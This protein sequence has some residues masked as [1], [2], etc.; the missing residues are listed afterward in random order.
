M[1]DLSPD[2]PL[3]FFGCGNMGRAM[4]DGWLRSDVNPAAFII[5]DPAAAEYPAGVQHFTDA[6]L[7]AGQVS[8]AVIAV[9]PQ[10]F[11]QFVPIQQLC[12][13]LIFLMTAYLIL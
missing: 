9:K 5:V 11:P 6:T 7:Y 13:I 1:T 2:N 4:L 8:T 3:L 12:L 10:M